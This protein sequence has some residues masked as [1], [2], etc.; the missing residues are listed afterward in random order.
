MAYDLEEQEKIDALKDWWDKNGT[1][2]IVLALIFAVAILGWRGYQW[3]EQHQATKAMGY[4][5]AL[6]LASTQQGEESVSRLL[7]AS[8]VL[9][10]EHPKSGYATRGALIAAESLAKQNKIDEAK[11]QLAWVIDQ[12]NDVAMADMARLRMAGLLL[13][14]AEFDAALQQLANPSKAYQGLYADRRGD[15][16]FAKAQ[17]DQARSEWNS[18][19]QLLNNVSYAQIV[20]LKLDALGKD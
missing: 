9:R 1:K 2:V 5:E 4:F 17:Y 18:A 7:A 15:I 20:Q 19:L 14:Q 6:E 8:N 11:A 12:K 10:T 16:Y 13:D 3:N